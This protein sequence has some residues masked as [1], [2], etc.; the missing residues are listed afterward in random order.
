MNEGLPN[1]RTQLLD[2][3]ERPLNAWTAWLDRLPLAA[4]LG[5]CW[6]AC[7]LAVRF[8]PIFWNANDDIAMANLANS[9]ITGI[10]EWQ[11]VFINPLWGLMLKGLYL[12]SGRVP[13]YPWLF[14]LMQ[15][16][17]WA[18]FFRATGLLSFGWQKWA[19]AFAIWLG[20]SLFV[21]IQLQFTSAASFPAISALLFAAAQ[22]RQARNAGQLLRRIWPALLCFWL[23]WLVRKEAIYLVVAVSVP[24]LVW[25]VFVEK[26]VFQK[27]W[28]ALILLSIFCGGALV[29]ER[30][31]YTGPEWQYFTEYNWVRGQLQDARPIPFESDPALMRRL[32]W[33]EVD[34]F[35][36]YHFRQDRDPR[37]DL[38][39]I[40]QLY[41]IKGKQAERIDLSDKVIGE[42]KRIQYAG[43]A[44][45]RFGFA[46]LALLAL[47]TVRKKDMAAIAGTIAAAVGVAAAF[48]VILILKDRVL[49]CLLFQGV[50]TCF[51]IGFYSARG[52][53]FLRLGL[54]GIGLALG[55]LSA[56]SG[57]SQG[58]AILRNLPHTYYYL[59]RMEAPNSQNPVVDFFSGSL[60]V[61]DP[62]R[63]YHL[64]LAYRRMQ[65]MPLGWL[66]YSPFQARA[67]NRMGYRTDSSL[68]L[69][70]A[71]D[72]RA[73]FLLDPLAK[74]FLERY[75]MQRLGRPV[76]FQPVGNRWEAENEKAIQY[77]IVIRPDAVQ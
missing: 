63:H 65:P 30:L 77:R 53:S 2:S 54:L 55:L 32:G 10:P 57:M 12:I 20:L 62:F 3:L 43:W 67:M 5:L 45:T 56:K 51:F 68:F 34:H 39:S 72:P 66:S 41:A 35:L 14:V 28:P 23:C 26:R 47:G 59:A 9:R 36:F 33:T 58:L 22:L 13:W 1:R 6:A 11:L 61:N 29:V 25:L 7:W 18:L 8:L 27:L 17:G 49:I 37:F 15:G 60:A 52:P 46:A 24:L 73:T 16:F 75:L 69:Q 21:L 38:E 70:A 50:A 44:W 74:P 4:W 71:R 40:R 19:W 42:W 48:I 31:A 76:R 64:P